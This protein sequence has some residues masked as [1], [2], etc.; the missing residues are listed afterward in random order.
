MISVIVLEN[1]ARHIEAGMPR[2]Q[3]TLQGVREVGFTVLAMSLA[4]VAIFI[5]LLFMGDVIGRILREFAMTLSAAVLISLVLSLTTAPMLCAHLLEPRSHRRRGWLARAFEHAYRAVLRSYERSLVIALRHS[6]LTLA[7]LIGFAGLNVYLYIAAP[8]GLLP[9]QDPGWLYGV[10][11]TEPNISAEPLKNAF[12]ETAAMISADPAVRSLDAMIEAANS[13]SAEFHIFLK[14]RAQRKETAGEVNSRLTASISQLPGRALY[15]SSV[16]DIDLYAP[17]GDSG[18][19][20]Y[21]LLGD[22]I[23]V[24]R[25]WAIRLAEALKHVP[26]LLDP[27]VDEK[28]S[29]MKP[30]LPSTGRPFPGLALP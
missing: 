15:L 23:G 9:Q 2:L 30:V 14:P 3:A 5:P 29:G 21:V 18:Q 19:Y 6:G 11:I 16:Q 4:L 27:N 10:F 22:D 26:E 17:A 28:N 25:T 20:Q 1:I 12:E 7:V 8:K 24:L 13:S